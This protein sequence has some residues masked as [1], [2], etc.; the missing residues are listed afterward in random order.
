MAAVTK[1]FLEQAYLAYFGRPVDPNGALFW[2]QPG[3][4]EADV[5]NGFS[6]SAES[7]ALY[8]A[9]TVDPGAGF[10]PGQRDLQRAV[11]S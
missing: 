10:H 3:T 7:I 11:R 6:N 2:L 8:G 4:T 5:V 9:P 1:A